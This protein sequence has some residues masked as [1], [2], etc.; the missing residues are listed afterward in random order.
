MQQELLAC[1]AAPGFVC[2]W[3]INESHN[4]GVS[5]HDLSL[6]IEIYLFYPDRWLPCSN[7][8]AGPID[9]P[10][11]FFKRAHQTGLDFIEKHAGHLHVQFQQII[12]NLE[13]ESYTSSESKPRILETKRVYLSIKWR[14]KLEIDPEMKMTRFWSRARLKSPLVVQKVKKIAL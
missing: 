2:S 10:A 1:T 8:Q 13:L 5:S 3:Y 9:S 11:S 4:V 6:N 14:T 12:S 7:Y